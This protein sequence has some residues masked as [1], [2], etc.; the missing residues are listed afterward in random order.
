MVDWIAF[1]VTSFVDVGRKNEQETSSDA[2]DFSYMVSSR[3][4]AVSAGMWGAGCCP[5]DVE[6]VVEA[7]RR[8]WCVRTMSDQARGLVGLSSGASDVPLGTPRLCPQVVH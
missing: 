7:A 2:W 3:R 1:L 4:G 5:T 8:C 6:G